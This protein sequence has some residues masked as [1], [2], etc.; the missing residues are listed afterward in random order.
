MTAA[1]VFVLA[2][3]NE[4]LP[5]VILEAMACAR[6][7]VATDVGGVGEAVED[8]VTGHLVPPHE[9]DQLLRGLREILAADSRGDMGLAGQQRVRSLFTWERGAEETRSI[10]EE[11]IAESGTTA[12]DGR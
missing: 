7:V 8:G 1:D 2:S 9:P 12:L 11:L 3:H 6:P 5:N 10:Y 4:G